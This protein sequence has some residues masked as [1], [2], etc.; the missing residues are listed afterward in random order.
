MLIKK[1]TAF[2]LT[3]KLMLAFTLTSLISILLVAVAVQYYIGLQFDDYVLSQHREQFQ[4]DLAYLYAQNGDWVS[5]RRSFEQAMRPPLPDNADDPPP[6]PDEN[7]QE[8]PRDDDA[9]VLASALPAPARFV[10]ADAE[11]R[12]QI[13][14]DGY[15]IGER[16]SATLFKEGLAVVVDGEEI[17]RIITTENSMRRDPNED[18]YLSRTRQALVSAA[19]G[20]VL[21][22]LLLSFMLARLMTRPL[23][24]LKQGVQRVASGDFE[25]HVPVRSQDELGALAEAFNRMNKDLAR[26]H[27]LRRQMAADIAHDLRT[28]LTVLSGYLESMR[29]GV[30]KASTER[31]EMLYQEAQGLQYLV[32]DLRLLSLADAGELKLQRMAV[33]P[34][35]LLEQAAEAFKEQARQH[36]IQLQVEAGVML[37]DVYVDPD[38][39]GRVLRNLLSNALR[40]TPDGGKIALSAQLAKQSVHLIV[41]DTGIGIPPNQLSNIFERFYRIEAERNLETGESGLGLSIVKSIVDAHGGKVNVQSTL[42]KGTTFI[43]SLPPT[44]S[45]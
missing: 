5:I 33:S 38:R 36:D 22:A 12:V 6:L 7:R 26:Q 20:A 18:E 4:S 13:P 44:L 15:Q 25:Q 24:E 2:T 1:L 32:E 35:D 41:E 28:P 21:I 39:F 27:H 10:V 42:N 45:P 37:P 16:I 43:I 11:G 30:L 17:G 31:F 40:Y 19:V 23:K 29:D 34:Q 3:T 14:F 8:S 9:P